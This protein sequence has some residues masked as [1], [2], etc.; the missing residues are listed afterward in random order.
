MV[1]KHDD[2]TILNKLIFMSSR[3]NVPRRG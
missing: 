2:V 1:R 3:G